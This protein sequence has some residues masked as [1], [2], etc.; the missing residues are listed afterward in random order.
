M[1]PQAKFLLKFSW[2][3]L[4]RN[5]WRTLIM[6]LGLC[7]GTGYI[8]F[9][10]N[11]SK[12]GT[13]EIVN[14]FLKQYFGFHQVVSAK[15]YP[16]VDKKNFDPNWTISD[17]QVASLDSEFYVKRIT[18]PVFL[19]GPNKTLGSLLTGLEVQKESRLSKISSTVSQGRFLSTTGDKELILGERLAKRLG[20][21]INDNIALIGQALDGSVANDMF[22][23]VGLLS[24]GGGDMEET[25]ALT[26]IQSARDFAVVAPDK[27]H[28]YVNLNQN[29][30][31]LPT[32]PEA[33]V[34]SWKLILPEI[35]GSI[36]FM[37]RFTWIISAIL[38]LVISLG[39]G[40][41]LMITFL[42]REKEFHALN[43]IGA[44][45]SWVVMSLIIE[46]FFLGVV[47][48]GSGIVLGYIITGIFHLYPISLL[49]FTGGKPIMM[50]GI[51]ILPKVRLYASHEFAW[52]VPL[53]V[54]FFLTMSLVWPL[55]RVIQRSR[56]VD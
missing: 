50:G 6:A 41:T 29:S 17:T 9:A 56:R 12:S 38:V 55:Y 23:L 37:D 10:L 52:Q 26:T 15:Y 11:F 54:S 18:L 16:E 24:F 53:M 43:I 27:F 36:D 21:K 31:V 20:L 30:R 45:S 3:N 40:N 46:V 5:P 25:V 22:T 51:A 28:Q 14:D 48:I 19:S 1:S 34:V 47:G 44:R 2:R 33:S 8:I 39:L 7:F 42:E 13:I 32:V 49:L 35:A 4:G